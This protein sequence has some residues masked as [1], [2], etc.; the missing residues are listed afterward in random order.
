MEKE[1]TKEE[2]NNYM[3]VID[4]YIKRTEKAINDL[5]KFKAVRLLSFENWVKFQNGEVKIINL[6]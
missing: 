4:E 1:L 6:K 5:S 3:K 2:Y